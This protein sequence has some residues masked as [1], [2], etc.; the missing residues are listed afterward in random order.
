MRAP[1]IVSMFLGLFLVSQVNAQDAAKTG[2]A[3]A[4]QK[5]DMKNIEQKYWQPSDQSYSVVQS[6]TYAKEKKF[7]VSLQTGPLLMDDWSTG[8]TFDTA[9]SYYFSERWGVELQGT[10][11]SLDDNDFVGEIASKGGAPDHGK[12]KSFI[13]AYARWVPFYSKMSFM[14]NKV[15]YFDMSFGLGAGLMSYEQQLTDGVPAPNSGR[16]TE[17]QSAPAVAFD[18]SQTYFISPKLAFRADYKMRFFNEEIV[19]YNDKG[20][21]VLKGDKLRDDLTTVTSLNFGLTYFF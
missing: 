1:L 12:A 14:G 6:R 2:E 10:F 4:P 8:F 15:I 20:G 16:V 5:V 17:A 21:G 11:Y 19:A 7:G 3:A 13:G 18:I 9:I